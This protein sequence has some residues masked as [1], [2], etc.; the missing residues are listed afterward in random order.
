MEAGAADAELAGS[1]F[2]RGQATARDTVALPWLSGFEQLD[3]S[4]NRPPFA[5]TS[6]TRPPSEQPFDT[7]LLFERL[8]DNQPP[9][10]PIFDTQPLFGRPFGTQLPFRLPFGTLP[11]SE[12]LFGIAD[13]ESPSMAA[14]ELMELALAV[15]SNLNS[16]PRR[17]FHQGQQWYLKQVQLVLEMGQEHLRLQ[18]PSFDWLSPCGTAGG[19]RPFSFGPPGSTAGRTAEPPEFV[20]GYDPVAP[21]EASFDAAVE[22]AVEACTAVRAPELASI[23]SAAPTADP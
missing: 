23:E 5:S 6:D 15:I 9:F 2:E 1:A 17:I 7:Q 20:L 19:A 22:S 8:S 11:P 10:E 3:T 21:Q 16:N 13:P 14:V 12:L 18:L 4:G